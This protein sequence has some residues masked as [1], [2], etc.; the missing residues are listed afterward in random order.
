MG[1][2]QHSPGRGMEGGGSWNP[3]WKEEWNPHFPH[4]MRALCGTEHPEQGTF[5]PKHHLMPSLSDHVTHK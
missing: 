3:A 4:R 5:G 1:L 2:H